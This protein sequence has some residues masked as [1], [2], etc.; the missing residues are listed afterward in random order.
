[1]GVAS[2]LLGD[3]TRLSVYSVLKLIPLVDHNTGCYIVVCSTSDSPISSLHTICPLIPSSKS[4]WLLI[5]TVFI[6]LFIL[7]SSS[8]VSKTSKIFSEVYEKIK[9]KIATLTFKTCSFHS[10]IHTFVI[11]YSIKELHLCFDTVVLRLFST[12]PEIWQNIQILL[13]LNV[14][15]LIQLLST[16]KYIIFSYLCCYIVKWVNHVLQK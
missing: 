10:V 9:Q 3:L 4:L 6:Y 5:F 2:W 14:G 11:T 13:I 7:F 15:A 8:Y 16:K 12:F 1:M